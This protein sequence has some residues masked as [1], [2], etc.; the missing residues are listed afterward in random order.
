MLILLTMGKTETINKR[1]VD[2]YLNSEKQKERWNQFAKK[3]KTSLSKLVIQTME[4]LI[5]GSLLD[6]LDAKET[7]SKRIEEM[8]KEIEQ[9]K[10]NNNRQEK[11]IEILEVEL[12]R[13]KISSFIVPG[14]GFRTH[15]EE[16]IKILREAKAPISHDLILRS[17]KVKP[18]DTE[19][20]K[21]IS[22]ELE[23]LASYGLVK[24]GPRGWT[25]NEK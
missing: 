6:Q 9:L 17:I 25:W 12:S 13:S 18:T 5:G 4:S 14:P 1:R 20:V 23:A 19:G 7:L 22:N 21:G 15:N 8:D 10:T 16:L 24:Y 11:Y 2:V 3:Q